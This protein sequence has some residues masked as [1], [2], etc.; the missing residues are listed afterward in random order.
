MMDITELRL[1]LRAAGFAPI[2]VEGKEPHMRGWQEKFE[3]SDQEIRLWAATWHLATNTGILTR[4]TPTIDIDILDPEAA[5]A[6]EG[7]V[8]TRY[9]T[10]RGRILVR[11][12]LSPKRA[13]PFRTD[14]PFKKIAVNLIA[15]NGSEGQKLEFLAD[16]QQLVVFG[17]HPTT[18]QPYTWH[19]GQPGDIKHEDLPYVSESEA[20]AFIEEAAQL[21]I[22]EFGYAARAAR[23]REKKGN[24]GARSGSGTASASTTDTNGGSEDWA[25]LI[26]NFHAGSGLHD[27]I[28]SLSAKLVH[29]GM[30]DGA[31]VNLLR[32]LMH[33]SGG[34]HNERWRSRYDDIPRAVSTAREKFASDTAALRPEE[35]PPLRFID[36]SHWDNE[37]VPEQQWTV[38]NRIPRR[39]CVLFSGEGAAGKSTEQLHLCAAHVLARDWLGTMPE[40]GPA[41]FI[42]AEDEPDVMHRRLA[43]I[44]EHY[45][46]TFNDLIKGGLH[47]FSLFA[48]DAVVA[49]ASRS[50]KIEPT[51]LYKQ[52]LEAV[53]DIKPVMIGVASSANVYAG[54]EI[55]RSQVQ[56]FVSLMTR[57]A[58]VADGS[59]VLISHPSLTGITSETGISGTT[60]WHNAVRARF[61]MK[62]VKPESGE[63]PDGDLREI[64]FLKNN[65]GPRS[66]SIV[67]RYQNGLFLPVP[68]I[69]SLD[70]VAKEAR[71]NEVFV[72]LVR[73]FT[74]E[75]RNVS[76]KTGTNYAPALFAREEEAKQAAL[77]SKAF[78]AAMRRLFK[79]GKI[80]NEPYGRQSRG[81]HRLALKS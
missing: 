25:R 32:G 52:I 37:P 14:Q 78:E 6:V 17:I 26:E 40:P 21:L 31:A 28:T 16:G 36:M 77:N 53:G 69:A 61:Y 54:S 19:G 12:G 56:Q 39:Q 57:L 34:A 11:I 7:L 29:T 75:N 45:R 46:M 4:L 41:L 72:E 68:G 43:A 74:R 33:N 73:R 58:V 13:I 64:V 1:R 81:S 22:T 70:K 66:E 79:N 10:E 18:G 60:Q 59:L 47:L 63:E 51:P 27:T 38:L 44:A 2:P 49:T 62:G 5:Q 67:L 71:A 76:D 65:Y 20:R 50:G 42:D 48:Q 15:P 24:S 3:T 80:W 30:D 55:D 23:Q 8:R 9:E 35:P